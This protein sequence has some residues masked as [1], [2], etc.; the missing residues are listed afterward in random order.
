[1]PIF[2]KGDV[3]IRYEEAGAGFQDDPSLARTLRLI[4]DTA[5]FVLRGHLP[6]RPLARGR[7]TRQTT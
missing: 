5:W 7:H 3:R 6:P 2:E 4:G 1:M